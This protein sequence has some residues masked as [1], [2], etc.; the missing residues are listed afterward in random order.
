QTLAEVRSDLAATMV[1]PGRFTHPAA[2]VTVYASRI[3]PDGTIHDLFID[4]IDPKGRDI[5]LTARLGRLEAREGAPML[6]LKDGS[7]EELSPAGVLN[8]LSFDEY[9]FDLKPILALGGPVRYKLSDRY[10]HELFFPDLSDPWNRTNRLKLLAEGHARFAAPLYAPAFML[11]ALAAILGGS[12]RRTGYGGRIAVAA[13]AALVARTLGFAAEAA[14]GGAAALNLLQYLV[15]LGTAA[16]A[17]AALF[18]APRRAGV[19]AAR[20]KAPRALAV[21]RAA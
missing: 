20:A 19:P 9:P 11:I 21:R 6:V 2:G 17:F 5:T 8:V 1:R 18:A 10:P 3:D 12:F 7:N 13:A 4:R 15:P 14:A 16:L